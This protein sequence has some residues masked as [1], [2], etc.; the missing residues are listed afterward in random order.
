MERLALRQARQ[1]SL[2]PEQREQYRQKYE[3]LYGARI[4]Q[5]EA[6]R[7]ASFDSDM[8]HWDD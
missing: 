2:S 4:Q 5:E 6:E 7:E 8:D 3:E 1:T